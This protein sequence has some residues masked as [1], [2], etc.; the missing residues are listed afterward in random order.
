MQFLEIEVKISP[1]LENVFTGEARYRV[2]YGGRGSSK[3]WGF[4]SMLVI[5]ALENPNAPILCAREL[6]NSIKDSVHKLLADTIHR[7]GLDSIFEIGESFLRCKNGAYFIFKGLR[8]NSQEIKSLEGVKY[9]WIEEGQKVSRESLE[10]L[11]PTIRAP[12]SEIWVTFNPTDKDDAVYQ[13]FVEGKPPPGSRIAKVNWDDNPWFPEELNSERLY[14]QADD[15]EAYDHVWN[16]NCRRYMV[17]SIYG[18]L[19]ALVKEE[20]RICKVPYNPSFPVN[21][22]WDIGYSDTLSIGFEQ[23]VGKEPRIIDYYENHL[24][25]IDHYVK[26][27]KSKPYLYGVHVLPHDAGHNSLRTGKTLAK[28]MEDLGLGFVNKD[29]II[30]PQDSIEAGIELVR[31]LIPML[32]FDEES[33]RELVKALSSYQYEWDDE[34]Q[35]FKTRPLHDWSSHPSDMIRYMATWLSQK[36]NGGV[37]KPQQPQYTNYKPGSW[38]G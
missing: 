21:T 28:Q 12:G 7:M 36:K 27:V 38:M 22:F 10:V 25:A 13:M 20:G 8:T 16:G 4:A 1:K 5:K 6:Q 32:W 3:S 15:L 18:K 30:L 29:I 26:L 23:E 24:E 33:T 9:C 35:V 11:I 2:A 34:R 14:M 17:G 37:A 19:M 31:N